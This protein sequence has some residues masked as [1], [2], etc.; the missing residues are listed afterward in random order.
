[1]GNHEAFK[2]APL[3]Y[4]YIT[5][6]VIIIFLYYF[7]YHLIIG[8]MSISQNILESSFSY[9]TGYLQVCGM[10]QVFCFACET[11]L[12]QYFLLAS[13]NSLQFFSVLQKLCYTSSHMQIFF[14]FL[15]CDHFTIKGAKRLFEKM[16]LDHEVPGCLICKIWLKGL[17]L[18]R[19][20]CLIKWD[21][22]YC[23]PV[24]ILP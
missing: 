21:I 3:N 12:L 19:R 11:N 7:C 23:N 13:L 22:N 8:L 18:I 9:G 10:Q 24:L 1:M 15:F 4:Y 17:E 5:V 2:P 16:S 14:V 6:V 20:R